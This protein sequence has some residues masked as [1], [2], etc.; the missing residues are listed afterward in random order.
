MCA[1]Y[2]ITGPIIGLWKKIK[3]RRKKAEPI[4]PIQDEP[5]SGEESSVVE[6]NSP[7]DKSS[8]L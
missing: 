2:A 4:E 8:K 3:A 7:V 5:R 6:E 1:V